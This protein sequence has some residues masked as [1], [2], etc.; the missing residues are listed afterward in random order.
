MKL[1]ICSD[2]H[3]DA[4]ILPA[5]VRREAPDALLHLG[6]CYS[7]TVELPALFP[8]L[9]LYRIAGNNDFGGEVPPELQLVLGGRGLLLTHGHRY[10][11]KLGLTQLLQRA[12]ELEADAVLFGHT[13]QPCLD[14]RNGIWLLNPGSASRL[15]YQPQT[16]Y[17]T[18]RIERGAIRCG[19]HRCP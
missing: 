15:L 10:R 19:M 14:C 16:T 8:A 4:A 18:M 12:R 13:H 7:D 5:L 6:D 3:G 11:V 1:L 17:A 2:T 9:P